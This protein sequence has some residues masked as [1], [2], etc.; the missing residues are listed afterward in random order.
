MDNALVYIMTSG[1]QSAYD[2][3]NQLLQQYFGFMVLS[4]KLFVYFVCHVIFYRILL[5]KGLWHKI[6]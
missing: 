4:F 5:T 3:V 6:Y 2:F 1:I